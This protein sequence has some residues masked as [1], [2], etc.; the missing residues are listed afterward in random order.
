MLPISILETTSNSILYEIPPGK[1]NPL[2][3]YTAGVDERER[4]LQMG[5]KGNSCWYFVF[6]CIRKRIGKICLESFLMDR[7]IEILCSQRRKEQTAYDNSFPVP[8]SQLY[9]T[10]DKSLLMLMD[11]KAAELFLKSKSD[12]DFNQSEIQEG[13]S[14]LK[15]YLQEFIKEKKFPNFYEFLLFKRYSKAFEINM[16]FL[17]YFETNVNDLLEDEKWKKLEISKKAIDL[18]NFVRDVHADLYK[19]QRSSWKPAQGID[20]LI[21]ELKERG[22]LMVLG[23]FGQD[24]YIDPPFKMS[25]K[26][27]SREIYGWRPGAEHIQSIAR[28]AVLLVGAKKIQNKAFVF[29]IDPCDPSDPATPLDPSMR[30]LYMIS[31][32][33]LTSNICSL[34][35]RFESDSKIGYAYHGNFRIPSHGDG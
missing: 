6:N 23:N 18:D 2:Q 26:I 14:S 5:N 29:F 8:F 34:S 3:T 16:K 13:R 32:N 20:P 28:H 35:G 10:S 17:S 27:S 7:K 1:P 11:L 12:D 19:L 30:K 21:H 22:P 25:Q 33:N 31:L 9:T 4:V 15:P 24:A